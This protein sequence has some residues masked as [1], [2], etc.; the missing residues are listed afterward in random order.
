[1]SELP[2]ISDPRWERLLHAVEAAE[3]SEAAYEA[4]VRDFDPIAAA[5]AVVLLLVMSALVLLAGVG[6]TFTGM[7]AFNVSRAP[8]VI[9]LLIGPGLL[10]VSLVGMWRVLTSGADW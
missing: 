3:P 10:L 7:W 2:D 5:R 9:D 4:D 1:M 8:T 6:L